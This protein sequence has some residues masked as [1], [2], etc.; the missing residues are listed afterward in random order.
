MGYV[1]LALLLLPV[2]AGLVLDPPRRR[3]RPPSAAARPA[4]SVDR[5]STAKI[6]PRISPYTHD[7]LGQ[8]L[9]QPLPPPDFNIYRP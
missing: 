6:Q 2:L 4:P 8:P 9:K 7:A 1:V 5:Q 3:P